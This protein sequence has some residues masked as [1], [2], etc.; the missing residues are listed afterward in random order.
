MLLCNIYVISEAASVILF[1]GRKSMSY[2]T[3]KKTIDFFE[4]NPFKL[5]SG[6]CF[7]FRCFDK[8]QDRLREC[9]KKQHLF[10]QT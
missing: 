1:L 9:S 8:N 10:C 6:Y 7:P 2:K 4:K 5:A 3:V